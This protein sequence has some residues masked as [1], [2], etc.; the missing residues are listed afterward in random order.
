MERFRQQINIIGKEGQE[1]LAQAKIL[2]V[3][4]G[5]LGAVIAQTLAGIGVGLLGIADDDDVDLSNLYR[6]FLYL[7]ED[8]GKKKV[9]VVKERINK[10]CVV[11][12]Y[13]RVTSE[14]AKEIF[15]EYQVVV[16]ASD[17]FAT[18]YLINDICLDLNLPFVTGAVE[19]ISGQVT[20]CNWKGSPSYR[21]LFPYPSQLDSC[22]AQGV[23][24]TLPAIIAQI[25]A[26]EV[27]K[28]VTE[29]A[30]PLAGKLICYNGV[31]FQ[32]I[33]YK[34]ADRS[35]VRSISSQQAQTIKNA[36]FVDARIE[37][38]ITKLDPERPIIVY[39]TKGIR[40]FA[41]AGKIESTLHA[42]EIYSIFDDA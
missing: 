26:N 12:T 4:V 42:R 9:E 7:T 33:T 34:K 29:C 22:T 32:T 14:N 31:E 28:I 17:N 35:S 41:L 40:S 27:A 23:L 11:K 25:Q 20:T 30:E 38:D 21:D 10:D 8:I 2:L 18:R 3:G 24:G 16:D 5:G 39:C 15:C 19:K 1:K 6:Q 13:G 36:Q 37:V